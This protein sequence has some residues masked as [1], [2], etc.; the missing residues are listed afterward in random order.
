VLKQKY[1]SRNY[2]KSEF[3]ERQNGGEVITLRASRQT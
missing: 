2:Y 1:L 3:Y